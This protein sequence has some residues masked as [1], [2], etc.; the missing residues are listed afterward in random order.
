MANAMVGNKAEKLDQ[1][2]EKILGEPLP[3]QVLLFW[4]VTYGIRNEASHVAPLSRNKYE[5]VVSFLVNLQFA[6]SKG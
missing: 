3:P 2:I 6:K 4:Q 1:V 5:T